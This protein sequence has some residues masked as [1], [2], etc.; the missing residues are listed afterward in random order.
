MTLLQWTPQLEIDVPEIDEQHCNLVG[1]LNEMYRIASTG[2]G[3]DTLGDIFEE[4]ELYTLNHFRDE[5]ALM[6]K[7]GYEFLVEHQAEHQA[8]AV[9][10]LAHR[11]AYEEGEG[12]VTEVL[13]FLKRWLLTHLAG[14]DRHIGDFMRQRKLRA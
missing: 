8:L 14:P 13:E 4:L 2:E 11:R 10:V 3:H 5:E 7:L 1:L 12:E 6:H 9:Q